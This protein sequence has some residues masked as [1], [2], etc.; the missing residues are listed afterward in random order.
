MEITSFSLGERLSLT[1]DTQT[2]KHF[3]LNYNYTYNSYK[4]LNLRAC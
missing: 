4:Y 3:I 1:L 2:L